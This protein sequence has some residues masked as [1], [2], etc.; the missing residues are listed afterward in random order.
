MAGYRAIGILPYIICRFLF[1]Y[2]QNTR[3]TFD[4]SKQ[5]SRRVKLHQSKTIIHL[6]SEMGRG[7]GYGGFTFGLEFG[8]LH[9]F[10]HLDQE[11][12]P[13][14]SD[15]V[16]RTGV[17]DRIV[18]ILGGDPHTTVHLKNTLNLKGM[19]DTRFQSLGALYLLP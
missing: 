17:W 11:N 10:L 12:H 9:G 14:A 5:D 16:R 4:Y 18:C 3:K 7:G 19:Q 13:Y 8:T 6:F 15:V 2:T 1:V